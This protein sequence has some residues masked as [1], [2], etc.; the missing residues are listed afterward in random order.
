[1]CNLKKK[2]YSFNIRF[3]PFIISAGISLLRPQTLCLEILG[4]TPV[5]L[6]SVMLLQELL[7]A[8]E[9]DTVY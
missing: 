5:V 9:T 3:C 8:R 2:R 4:Q 6:I 7:S 1:M